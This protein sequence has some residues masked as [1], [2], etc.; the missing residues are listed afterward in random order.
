MI[1][2]MSHILL[3]GHASDEYEMGAARD[4]HVAKEFRALLKSL[5]DWLDLIWVKEGATN[6]EHPGRWHIVRWHPGGNPELN[7]YWVVQTPD[8]AYCIPNQTHLDALMKMD[9]RT[10]D[11][12]R[13]IQ[14]GRSRKKE[15]RR[16]AFE[17]KREEFR[18]TLLERLSHVFDTRIAVTPAMKARATGG[19][20]GPDGEPIKGSVKATTNPAMRPKVTV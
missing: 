16:K 20:L 10:R 11:V 13:G 17:A 6:F 4:I 12:Y 15:E 9:T 18:E 5:D 1:C 3:P 8:G 14:E 19:L 2:A 7:V